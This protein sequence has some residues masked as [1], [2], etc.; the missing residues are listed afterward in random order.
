MKETYKIGVWGIARIGFAYKLVR[1]CNFEY[2]YPRGF[3]HAYFSP[4]W[5]LPIGECRYIGIKIQEVIAT[6]DWVEMTRNICH[7]QVYGKLLDDDLSP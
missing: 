2:V 7:L 3:R 4:Q 5:G 6:G 1:F